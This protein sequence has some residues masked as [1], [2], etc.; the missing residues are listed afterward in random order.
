VSASGGEVLIPLAEAICV[1]IDPQA[2]RIVIDPPVGLLE[3]NRR[4]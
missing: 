4:P 1:R 3:V 2:R